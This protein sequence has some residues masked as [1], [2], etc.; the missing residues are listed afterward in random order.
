MAIFT[1][2]RCIFWHPWLWQIGESKWFYRTFAQIE[3]HADLLQ[4]LYLLELI[5]RTPHLSGQRLLSYLESW[6][7]I[8]FYRVLSD[9]SD[10][11]LYNFKE[12]EGK[13]RTWKSKIAPILGKKKYFSIKV[14]I[15]NSYL[16]H[17]NTSKWRNQIKI[18]M[19]I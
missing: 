14:F 4:A 5:F 13:K 7:N 6:H 10:G 17:K 16:Q 9:S 19:S 8:V 15:Y 2:W 18:N 11:I 1:R 3:Y 12:K